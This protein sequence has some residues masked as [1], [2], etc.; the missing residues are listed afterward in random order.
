MSSI[1]LIPFLAAALLCLVFLVILIVA[2]VLL[3]RKNRAKFR[4][5][6]CGHALKEDFRLCPY[7]GAQRRRD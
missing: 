7:C 6:G 2:I 5:E 4:C 1:R 3:V